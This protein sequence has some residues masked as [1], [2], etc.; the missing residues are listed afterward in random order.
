MAEKPENE[1]DPVISSSQP[2]HKPG[3]QQGPAE[4]PKPEKETKERESFWRRAT[5]EPVVFLA[6]C[7][8][9]ANFLLLFV[10]AV[11]FRSLTRAEYIAEKAAE[12]ARKSAEAAEKSAEVARKTLLAAQRPWLSVHT[13]IGSDLVFSRKE[14]GGITIIYT[15]KNVGNSPAIDVEV[16][17]KIFPERLFIS[18]KEREEQI[19]LCAVEWTKSLPPNRPNAGL[20][21]F[22][23][24]EFVYS[25][26]TGI[27]WEDIN[28]SRHEM[29]K[30]YGAGFGA[31]SIGP[32]LVGCVSYRFAVDSSDHTTGF[33]YYLETL[34]PRFPNSTLGIKTNAGTTPAS[35]LKLDPSPF[36]AHAD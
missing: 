22:P 3:G 23:N 27:S 16:N 8:V 19:K 21:L 20:V 24:E 28:Q 6:L 30:L 10:Y 4:A 12:A 31:G 5:R 7:L 29:E 9:V 15:V 18:G 25:I 36:G 33:A 11:Q 1:A 32:E 17:A 34:D 13:G 26:S 14:G 35:M 2:Y